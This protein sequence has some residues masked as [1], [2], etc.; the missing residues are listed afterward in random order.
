[1]WPICWFI[2]WVEVGGVFV[3]NMYVFMAA[4]A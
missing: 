4:L 3:G 1:L 2:L